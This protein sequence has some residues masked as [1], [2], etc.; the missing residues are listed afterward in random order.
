MDIFDYIH[1]RGLLIFDIQSSNI[2]IGN[3]RENMH[4]V[5][6]F[7][8][9]NSVEISDD[10]LPKN[11]LLLLGLT[12]IELNGVK[13]PIKK[14]VQAHAGSHEIIESLIEEW[15]EKYVNVSFTNSLVKFNPSLY[16]S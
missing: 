8:F 12:L 14:E 1:S 10:L 11:D 16:T 5:Y 7:D 3:S 2:A 4:K 6:V 13:F 15:D 9:D